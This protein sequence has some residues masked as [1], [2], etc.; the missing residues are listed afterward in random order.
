MLELVHRTFLP[1]A[2]AALHPSG[3]DAA[4]IERLIPFLKNQ[5]AINGRATAYVCENYLCKLPVTEP[6]RLKA[7]LNP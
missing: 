4:A 7:L 2:V 6:E 3:P 5:D 1:R